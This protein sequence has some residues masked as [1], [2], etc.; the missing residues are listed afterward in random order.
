MAHNGFIHGLSSLKFNNKLI[1]LIAEEGID[2]GGDEPSTVKIYSAQK[3]GTPAVE[4]ADN[5]GSDTISF[6]L[7]ELHPE[8]LK[9]VFGGEIDTTGGKKVWK[10]PAS[11]LLQEGS[12]EISTHDGTVIGAGKAS[13]LAKFSGKIKH[14][15]VLGVKCTLTVLSD[16]ETTPMTFGFPATAA[17]PS[18]PSH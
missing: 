13:L 6:T 11:K 15:E 5:P 10:A 8:N 3:R 7:I 9:D 18:S 4:L 2:W 14:N 12:F 17:S 16:G 1:G